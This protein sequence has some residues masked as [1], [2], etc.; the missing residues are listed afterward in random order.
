MT[1]VEQNENLS[2]C[3]APNILVKNVRTLKTTFHELQ[4]GVSIVI[5]LNICIM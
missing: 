4:S 1:G 2:V 5:D 3:P